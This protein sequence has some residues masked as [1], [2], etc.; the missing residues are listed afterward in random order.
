MA[1]APRLGLRMPAP[2]A[3]KLPSQASASLTQVKTALIAK[4]V[5]AP[6]RLI[7][8][9]SCEDML[10][11]NLVGNWWSSGKETLRKGGL[12]LRVSSAALGL[13]ADLCQYACTGTN[14][15]ARA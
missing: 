15:Q 6:W 8:A 10:D 12:G 3:L 13:V 7:C 4:S 14:C 5:H 11:K 1:Q 9:W 2:S